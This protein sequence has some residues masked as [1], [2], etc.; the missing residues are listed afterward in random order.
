MMLYGV[1]EDTIVAISSPAGMGGVAVIRCSGKKAVSIVQRIFFNKKKLSFCWDKLESRKMY[2]GWIMEGDHIIDEVMVCMFKGP[3]SY[4]GED[5]VEV[6]CHGS[7]Y[8]QQKILQ[9]IIDKGGRLANAGEFTIRAYLNGKMNLAEAEAIG[10]L[11]HSET[12]SSHR[13][14]IEEWRGGY[15]ILIQELR[16]HLLNFTSLLELELDFSEE[17]VEF[18]NRTQ[19]KGL[20]EDTLQKLD[21]LL[22]SFYVGNVIKTGIPVVI[23]GEP[24]TGKSTL[25]N[26]LLNDERAIVSDIPGTTRDLI[27]DKLVIKGVLFRIIDTAGIREA[28]NEI[29]KIGIERAKQSIQKAMI[30]ILLHDITQYEEDKVKEYVQMVD[31][32]NPSVSVVNVFNKVDKMKDIINIDI[33]DALYISAKERLNIHLLKERLFEI[34][35]QKGYQPHQPMVSNVRHY[36]ELKSA[37]AYLSKVSSSLSSGITTELIAEDMRFA[38]YHLSNITGNITSEEVLANIFSNFC[39]GK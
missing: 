16:L 27:E 34:V 37:R 21:A 6:Y 4:T 15:K 14:A 1:S 17:D 13:L 12:E 33:K 7:I 10:D 25:L 8:V 2:H 32:I 38:I 19:L 29:E 18:A 9:I 22:N 31:G 23:L 28:E 36:N 5:V 26:A 30:V 11:I 20:L 3:Q 24:N 35:M 39:I